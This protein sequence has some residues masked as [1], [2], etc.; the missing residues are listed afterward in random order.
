M[1]L[2]PQER[3]IL[4]S[5]ERATVPTLRFQQISGVDLGTRERVDAVRGLREKGLLAPLA[6]GE[7]WLTERGVEVLALRDG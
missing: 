3:L 6:G 5:F 1:D 2:S 4:T 7:Y